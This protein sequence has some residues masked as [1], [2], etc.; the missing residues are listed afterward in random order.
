MTNPINNTGNNRPV[1]GSSESLARSRAKTDSDSASTTESS[2]SDS[3]TIS[4][5]GQQLNGLLQQVDK[6]PE[7]NQDRINA[8][9]DAIAKGQYPLDAKKIAAN[10]VNLEKSLTE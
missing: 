7:V 1:S 3:V 2:A 6:L 10:L 4:E 9:K 5:Q 8:I